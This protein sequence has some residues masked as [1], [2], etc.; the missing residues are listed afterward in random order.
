M[1]AATHAANDHANDRSSEPVTLA[2]IPQHAII[3]R[4]LCGLQ[5]SEFDPI[6]VELA[7][8][9]RVRINARPQP[10]ERRTRSDAAFPPADSHPREAGAAS[11][12]R[13][14]A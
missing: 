6:T 13:S 5:G 2:R 4:I 3:E 7:D 14:V 10:G 9:R 11:A 8:G 1:N 12:L